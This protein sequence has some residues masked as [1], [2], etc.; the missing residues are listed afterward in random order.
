VKED[1]LKKRVEEVAKADANKVREYTLVKVENDSYQVKEDQYTVVATLRSYNSENP[2]W[3]ISTYDSG[4]FRPKESYRFKDKESAFEFVV[5]VRKAHLAEVKDSPLPE[6]VKD[7]LND[8]ARTL[9]KEFQA[10]LDKVRDLSFQRF[11]LLLLARQYGVEEAA[12]FSDDSDITQAAR[13][14]AEYC[15]QGEKIPFFTEGCLYE[16]V[17]KEDARS[18]LA[19]MS[20]L[21]KLAAPEI[22]L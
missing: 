3:R 9:S 5:L 2:Y 4:K 13:D 10:S 15:R 7:Y 19:L 8:R 6:N 12:M 20:R 21:L 1:K 16:L 17:G 11:S 14:L 22:D 18:I